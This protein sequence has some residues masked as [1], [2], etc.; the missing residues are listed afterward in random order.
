MET[1]GLVDIWKD[2]GRRVSNNVIFIFRG[3][4]FV[5]NVIINNIQY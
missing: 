3:F 5:Q 2:G 4:W 1:S